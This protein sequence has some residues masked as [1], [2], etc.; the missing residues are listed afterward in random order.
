[1]EFNERLEKTMTIRQIWGLVAGAAA[2]IAITV[3]LVLVLT[4][5][6]DASHMMPGGKMM[7]G[8]TQSMHSMPSGSMMDGS[9]QGM[10][11]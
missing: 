6:S 4:G 5:G 3:V 7:D 2:V 10:D 9:S 1:M 11:R 8:Q